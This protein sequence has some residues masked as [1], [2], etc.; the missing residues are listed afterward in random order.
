[1]TTDPALWIE[2]ACKV[3]RRSRVVVQLWDLDAKENLAHFET[4]EPGAWTQIAAKLGDFTDSAGKPRGR[5]VT[6]GDRGSC[7][8]IFAGEKGEKVDLLVDDVRFYF[9]D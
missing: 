9:V 5:P 2:V 8:T 4:V 7:F 6:K 1:M 3:D